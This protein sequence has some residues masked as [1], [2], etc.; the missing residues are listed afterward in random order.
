[1]DAALHMFFSDDTLCAFDFNSFF[2]ARCV[3]M[4]WKFL[5]VHF[6]IHF[7]FIS[8]HRFASEYPYDD[9]WCRRRCC[10]CCQEVKV[11]LVSFCVCGRFN[12]F[13]FNLVY[14]VSFDRWLLFCP[15]RLDRFCYFR[16]LLLRFISLFHMQSSSEITWW[17]EQNEIKIQQRNYNMY[18]HRHPMCFN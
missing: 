2:Y 3:C 15:F 7:I 10:C 18:V 1:M 11:K 5:H 8:T 4:R 13:I 16:L 12:S 6:D 14:S 17:T 9:F